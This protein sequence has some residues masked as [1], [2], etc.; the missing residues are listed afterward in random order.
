MDLKEIHEQDK[1]TA[2]MWQGGTADSVVFNCSFQ[3]QNLKILI[4]LFH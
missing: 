4:L 2:Q 1:R 3:S